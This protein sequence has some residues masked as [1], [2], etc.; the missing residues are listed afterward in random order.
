MKIPPPIYTLIDTERDGM[1][2]V[3]MV[4]QALLGFE[5]P[6]D[7]SWHLVISLTPRAFAANG[8][9]TSAEAH[10]LAEQEVRIEDVLLGTNAM[11]L[12]RQTWNQSRVSFYRVADPAVAN[13]VLTTLIEAPAQSHEWEYTMLDDPDWK[14]AEVFLDLLRRVLA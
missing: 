5:H 13:H 2:A 11:F 1:P 14:R 9:P 10:A 7:F 4:N 8:M 3:V 6:G 12:A